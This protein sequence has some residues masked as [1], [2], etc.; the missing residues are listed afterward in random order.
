VLWT[1]GLSGSWLA[2]DGVAGTVPRQGEA[3]VASAG[4]VAVLA[5][6]TTVTGYQTRTGQVRWQADLSQLA[7]GSSIDSVRAWPT[8]VAVGVSVPTRQ[9]GEV[10]EELVLS[11]AT[12]GQLRS[13]PAADYGGAALA[14]TYSAVIVGPNA[15]TDYVNKS[16]R[17]IWR[18]ATGTAA[19]AWMVSGKDLYVT[20]TSN[21]YLSSSPVTALSQIDMHTGARRVIRPRGHA[22]AGTLAAVADGVL[23]FTGNGELSAYRAQTGLRL[24]RR[25]SAVL[26]L[27]DQSRKSIYIATGDNL[28]ALDV[29]TGRAL[30]RPASSVSASLYAVKDGVALGLDDNALGEAWGYSMSARKAVWTSASLPWP[31][32]FVDLTGLGGSISRGSAVTLVT[33]C[34]GTGG[35]ISGS[36][37]APCSRPEL[38]AIRY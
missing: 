14:S 30:G 8:A 6:G 19:Q 31:H 4:D 11:A 1:S 20:Q 34:A 10:R 9:G 16:G 26:E 38:A 21:G 27:V 23:L 22:F 29:T 13:Y 12:G 3:Y 15:V 35:A 5:Y 33:T 17:V 2:E 37:S 18:H 32:F 36:R 28:T 24:W 7:A 25:A